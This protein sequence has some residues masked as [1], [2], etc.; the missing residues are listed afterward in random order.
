VVIVASLFGLFLIC[1]NTL[2][3][4]VSERLG[5]F[6]LLRAVGIAPPRLLWWVFLEAF[7]AIVP[8][9]S[10]GVLSA[11]LVIRALAGAKLNLP[12]IALIPAAV[13]GCALIALGLA[14]LSS[15]LPGPGGSFARVP[16]LGREC[17]SGE[18]RAIDAARRKGA[19]C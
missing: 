8:A 3:H 19:L 15:V 18:A 14:I 9:A 2:I 16:A 10:A 7:V 4:S 1:F 13:A 12:G 17:R 11:L 5:E 6:A